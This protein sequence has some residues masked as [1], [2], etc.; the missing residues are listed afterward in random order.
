MHN[1]FLDFVTT[2]M[3]RLRQHIR[4]QEEQDKQR[5]KDTDPRRMESYQDFD[6][7]QELAR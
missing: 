5:A 7:V 6:S 1:R 4:N 3:L 2:G